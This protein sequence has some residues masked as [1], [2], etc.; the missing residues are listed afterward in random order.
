MLTKTIFPKSQF[1]CNGFFS[2]QYKQ[3][4]YCWYVPAKRS[5]C[6]LCQPSWSCPGVDDRS[7]CCLK[8]RARPRWWCSLDSPSFWPQ[9]CRGN[10]M[11]AWIS[12][13]LTSLSSNEIELYSLY[14]ILVFL[15]KDCTLCKPIR[16][17]D[18]S[19]ALLCVQPSHGQPRCKPI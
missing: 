16:Y 9:S 2:L 6:F 14:L 7:P 15:L 5:C 11:F 17:S 18:G 19:H 13:L 4:W 12:L 10:V 3:S 8:S 1:L